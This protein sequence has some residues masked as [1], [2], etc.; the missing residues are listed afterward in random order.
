MRVF[1]FLIRLALLAVFLVP[2]CGVVAACAAFDDR[3]AVER[4]AEFTPDHIERAKRIL[5]ANDPRRLKTGALRTVAV[6]AGDADLALNYLTQRYAD[7][8]A[9]ARFSSG[10][11]HITATGRVSALPSRP[12]INVAVDLVDGSPLPA[13]ERCRVGQLPLPAWLAEAVL[14]RLA[15]TVWS[16][17]DLAVLRNAVKKVEFA[18]RGARLTYQWDEDLVD[19]VRAALVPAEARERLRV[20]QQALAD[21]TRKLPP[22]RVSLAE[23]LPP[24]FEVAAERG[25]TSDPVVENRA[26]ILVLTF[27][28]DGRSLAEIVPEARS[29]P[30]APRRA[31]TLNRRGDFPKHFMISAALSANTG[32]PF[33]DAVGVYKEVA[34]SRGGS[35]FSFN[36]IA[37]DRAGSRLGQLAEGRESARRLQ[38]RL[39]APLTERVL[40]PVTSDLPEYMSETEFKRRFGGVGAPAYARMMA[41]IDA[42]IAALPL[43]R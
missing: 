23:L 28:V 25:A 35:G 4:A 34:D 21:A 12:Y 3:P 7:G 31:V 30:P 43:Y 38:T 24:V 18:E 16:G 33:A 39:S 42:R 36:D 8:G 27:Y 13:I 32:G 14:G 6:T 10:R 37:A 1:R 19:T 20:Y 11:L 40:M 26:A 15:G 9:E 29:W 17:G 41:D 5:A 2:A 22:G